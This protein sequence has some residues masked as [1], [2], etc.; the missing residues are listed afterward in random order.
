VTAAKAAFATICLAS[1][2]AIGWLAGGSIAALGGL[3]VLLAA[4]NGYSKSY[5]P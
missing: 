4:V 1:G 3:A 5:S 2:I